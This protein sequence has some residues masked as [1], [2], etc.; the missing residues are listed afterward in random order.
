M[1]ENIEIR[2]GS[3]NSWILQ[4][5]QCPQEIYSIIDNETAFTF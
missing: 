1:V 3:S 2:G 4:I 5:P